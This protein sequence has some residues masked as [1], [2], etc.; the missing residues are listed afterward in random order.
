MC[1]RSQVK[2][3]NI[4]CYDLITNAAVAALKAALTDVSVE[5]DNP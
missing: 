1:S 3:V 4:F 2:S 5:P